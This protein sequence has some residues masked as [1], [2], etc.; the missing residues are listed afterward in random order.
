MAFDAALRVALETNAKSGSLNASL[1]TELSGLDAEAARLRKIGKVPIDELRPRVDSLRASVSRVRIETIEKNH[2]LI[3]QYETAFVAR[4]EKNA[5]AE[6]MR[7]NDA[8]S[9]IA[10]MADSEI[11]ALAIAYVDGA[12]LDLHELREI[13]ARAR[14][15]DDLAHLVESLRSEMSDRR[16]ETPWISE[17]EKATALADEI[18][19]LAATPPGMVRIEAD[20]TAFVVEVADLVDYNG[21]LDVPA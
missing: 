12:D 20:D 16:A 8:R 14:K 19:L 2:D 4:R 10:A 3:F 21:E 7:Q 15:S 5:S 18:D 6:I 11:E 1:V 9:R 13:Q 17:D